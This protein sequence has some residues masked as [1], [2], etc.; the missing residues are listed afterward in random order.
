M[1]LKQLS[2]P[3][4]VWIDIETTGLDPVVGR[5]L[6]IAMI[7]TDKNLTEKHRRTAVIHWPDDVIDSMELSDVVREMHLK[8]GLWREVSESARSLMSVDQS[9]ANDLAMRYGNGPKPPLAGSTISFDR[10]WIQVWFPLVAS[11]LHYRNVDVSTLKELLLRWSPNDVPETPDEEHR[12]ESDIV[13]SIMAL[14]HYR[15]ILAS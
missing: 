11:K 3:D 8:N 15:S 7:I 14:D 5:P 10:A 13:A 2:H 9:F 6:E 1:K 4:L 12:A